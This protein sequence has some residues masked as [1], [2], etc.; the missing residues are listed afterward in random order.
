MR[1]HSVSEPP[2]YRNSSRGTLASVDQWLEWVELSFFLISIVAVGLMTAMV[3]ADVAIRSLFGDSPGWLSEMPVF[4]NIMLT[5]LAMAYLFRRQQHIV[6][7]ALFGRLP[8]GLRRAVRLA[9]L[10][11]AEA[12][13]ISLAWAGARV[14]LHSLELGNVSYTSIEVPMFLPQALVPLGAALLAL[15]GL[16]QIMKLI[17][18]EPV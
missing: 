10:F 9:T 17:A 2:N 14:A 6:V 11:V 12:F 18:G 1:D 4:L 8:L 3:G 7:D 13:F 5:F 16:S 15:E